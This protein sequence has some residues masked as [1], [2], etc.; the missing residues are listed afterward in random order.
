MIQYLSLC[1]GLEVGFRSEGCDQGYL[2]LNNSNV[3]LTVV[4]YGDPMSAEIPFNI[5]VT[6]TPWGN[7][8]EDSG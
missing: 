5:T 7:S 2:L 4:N 6:L 3:T 8:E 1:S